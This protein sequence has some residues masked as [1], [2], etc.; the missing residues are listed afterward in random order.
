MP[1][2]TRVELAPGVEFAKLT[3]VFTVAPGAKF[4]RFCGNGVP[5]VLPSRAVVNETLLAVTAPMFCTVID[6]CTVVALS[7]VSVE[8]TTRFADP[9]GVVHMN[10]TG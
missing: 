1:P 10:T 9:H 5:L 7:R 3:T 6:A 2:T 4:P 8:F